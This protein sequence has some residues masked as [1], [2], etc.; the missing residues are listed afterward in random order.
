[1]YTSVCV[2]KACVCVCVCTCS[3]AC[4]HVCSHNKY[5]GLIAIVPQGHNSGIKT[6][7]CDDCSPNP[8]SLCNTPHTQ[9]HAHILVSAVNQGLILDYVNDDV[10]VYFPSKLWDIYVSNHGHICVD[11]SCATVDISGAHYDLL[12]N[13]TIYA[14]GQQNLQPF[15]HIPQAWTVHILKCVSSLKFWICP[16]LGMLTD[17]HTHTHTLVNLGLYFTR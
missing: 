7:Y 5:W 12:T 4:I 14:R 2:C 13:F 6:I 15:A 9:T 11:F 3:C 16:H 1:M 17:S 10:C 8:T